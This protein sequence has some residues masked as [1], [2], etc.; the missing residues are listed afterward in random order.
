MPTGTVEWPGSVRGLRLHPARRR[1]PGR[2]RACRRCAAR[3]PD[4][5]AGQRKGSFG[6]V[7]D[8]RCAA[9]GRGRARRFGRDQHAPISS[10][11]RLT[12]SSNSR[13]SRLQLPQGGAVKAATIS[14]TSSARS[15]SKPASS[16]CPRWRPRPA[17]RHS[18]RRPARRRS[19]A[20]GPR[21][22]GGSP[23]TRLRRRR[24]H[25]AA[26]RPPPRRGPRPTRGRPPPR[27]L[28]PGVRSGTRAAA[29]GAPCGPSG[30]ARTPAR[31]PWSFARLRR[32][33]GPAR[34]GAR[35]GRTVDGCRR[36]PRIRRPAAP[37]RRSDDVDTPN[38]PTAWPTRT[39]LHMSDRS[40]R[41]RTDRR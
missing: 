2:I 30:R 11:A 9:C 28:S 6:L 25:R 33:P 18:P 12:S 40:K 31:G 8:E 34:D 26:P 35:R 23:G 7:I 29:S 17:W 39:D 19:G 37:Q 15:C 32:K 24:R 27:R 5:P 14:G 21:V 41:V 36:N 16:P 13:A 3:R 38:T 22:G 1:R 20:A 4:R 10:A